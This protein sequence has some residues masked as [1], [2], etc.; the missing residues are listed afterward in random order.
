LHLWLGEY[1]LAA[2][3]EPGLAIWHL[4]QAQHRSGRPDAV[5]G[6]AA[7]DTAT[8]LHYEGAYA[9]A[10]SAF[11][12]LLNA[13]TALRGYDRRVAA[14][15]YRHAIACAGYH[16]QRAKLGVPEPERLD[17]LC[18]V[19]GLAVCLRSLGLPYDRKAALA[20]CRV[21]GEGSSLEDL[22]DAARTLNLTSYCLS[23]DD[24]GLRLLP[25][26]LIAYVEHDHFITVMSADRTGVAYL[27]SDCGP[28]PG[29]RVN[30]TW[31]QW[32]ALAP[33]AYFAISKRGS[34]KDR[35]LS[36]VLSASPRA[37]APIQLA[38][39]GPVAGLDLRLRP[40]QATLAT[41]LRGHVTA[42][43]NLLRISCGNQPLAQHCPPFTHCP[44][45]RPCPPGSGNGPPPSGCSGGGG[46]SGWRPGMIVS[47]SP[48][49]KGKTNKGVAQR[50][51]P[52]QLAYR[53]SG[54]VAGDPVNLATGEEEYEPDPDLVVYN[55]HG[56]AITWSR[57]YE[58][59]RGPAAAYNSDDFGVGWSH[60]YNVLVYDSS[61]AMN[62]QV[63]PGT[64]ANVATTGSDLPGSGL[65]WDI[66]QNG[67]TIATSAS[68]GGWSVSLA[69]GGGFNVTAPASAAA[70]MN[71]EARY[72]NGPSGASGFFDVLAA[73]SVPAG[74]TARL[75][76]NGSDAPAA[77]LTWDVLKGGL[78]VATSANP[79]G[80]TVSYGVGPQGPQFTVSC[81]LLSAVASNYEVRDSTGFQ[82][83]KPAALSVIAHRFKAKAGSKSLVL[84]NG[85]QVFFN[86]ASVPS[87]S[88][89]QVTCGV[90]AGAPMAVE[91][92]YSASDPCGTYKIT[93]PNR[94]K[95]ITTTCSNS[96]GTSG[97]YFSLAQ[98]Q[99][100]LGNAINF[101]YGTYGPTHFPAITSI[102]DASNG[103]TLLTVTRATNGTANITGISDAY[104]RSVYYHVGTYPT[105]NVPAGYPQSFQ[106]VDTVSQIV[107]TGTS[108]PPSRYTYGYQNLSDLEGSEQIPFLHTLTAPS[109]T[110]TGNSTATINYDP[111]TDFVS[112]VVDSNGNKRAYAPADSVHTAVTV[113]NAQNAVAYSYAAGFDS[114]LSVTNQTDG[115][116]STNLF[117]ADYADPNDPYQASSFTD[118]AGRTTSATWDAH[119][120]TQSIT[121]PRG[122]KTQFTVDYSVFSLGRI[123][124][125]QTGTKTPISI[126][127]YEPGG[128]VQSVASP[129]PGQSGG[130]S[131]VA[132]SF[133]YD[134][135]GNPLTR[136]LPGNNAASSIT[137]TC[138][139]TSDGTYSQGDA[140]GEPLTVTD[141]LGK[142]L[143][144]LRWDARGN[145]V[146]RT[147]ALGNE[148][149]LTYNLADQLTSVTYPATGQ[150]GAGRAKNVY[151]YLY[152]G[153]PLT[154]I[155]YYDESAALA[156]QV[157]FT[158]GPEGEFL[159][160]GGSAEPLTVTYDAQYRVVSTQDGNSH[161]TTYT[162]NQ[163]GHLSGIG[164]PGGD[165]IA[166]TS[167]DG[168]GNLLQRVNGRGITTNYLYTDVG[169]LLSDIEYPA[170]P[171]LN[172]HLSYD[173]YD[174]RGT[175]SD[176]CGSHSYS[177]D[178]GDRPTG[179]T[180]TYTGLPA[181]SIT[182]SFYADGSR[183]G[184]STPAGNFGYSYDG[185]G[186][187][188]GL[189]NPYSES[190][191]WT[192]L[193]NNWLKTQ[194]LGNGVTST[195]TY[196]A[197]ARLL[198]IST[199]NS[200]ST[201]LSDFGSMVYDA[202]GN[203][204]SLLASIP[205]IGAYG[206]STSYGYDT[207]NELT[208]EQS[209]RNGSYSNVFGYDGAGNATTFKGATNAFNADNQNTANTWDGDGNPTV[210]QGTS[211]AFDAEDRLTSV[212]A[213]LTAGYNGDDLRA[214]KQTSAGRTYFLYDG[215]TPIIEM[216][217][218]GNVTAV[219]TIGANGL[220]ARRSGGTSVSYAFDAQ[221]SVAQRLD[222]GGNILTNEMFDAYGVGVSDHPASDPFGYLAQEGY[223][224][225]R[226]SGLQLLTRRYYDPGAGRFLNRDPLG[227][228]GGINLY[229]YA[230]DSPVVMS[231]PS[232]LAP[233]SGMD[234]EELAQVIAELVQEIRAR[235]EER[236]VD[237][238]DYY[239]GSVGPKGQT[240]DGEAHQLEGKQQRLRN[241][242][243]RFE[244]LDCRGKGFGVPSNA[245]QWA[246]API[247]VEP[248]PKAAPTKIE[249]W[250]PAFTPVPDP[251]P[252]IPP[253][254][255]N[256]NWGSCFDM[257]FEFAL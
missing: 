39:N 66:V 200:A 202:V 96:A 5:F 70:T 83:N 227:Y 98:I 27:C 158:Y 235:I 46:G 51:K 136:T 38:S 4:R 192:Y 21:T 236:R 108:N 240:W 73:G 129:V 113:S 170:T 197:R 49:E 9:K 244:D 37:E 36:K 162:Y 47:A 107:P 239:H 166:F 177:F 12:R 112:S 125:V 183:S 248:R 87:S 257:D 44:T 179:E 93:F 84:S 56:P 111:A 18:G 189:S 187:P 210:Y 30:L 35:L 95:W 215:E 212:G 110:G 150:T 89:P 209:A 117:T 76:S 169:G 11:R 216:D 61:A 119:G 104:G 24:E 31:Q 163:A 151:A 222:S 78:S 6:L 203:R 207:K 137:T 25:K 82:G 243:K 148:V 134:S 128:L 103:S 1:E 133:T 214:W 221:G 143:W 71:Y 140:I 139:Y 154:S 132:T 237:K 105:T 211:L 242:L 13:K 160:R 26:P 198:E 64:T 126:S 120:T 124:A 58:S 75:S 172:V 153:G 186:R 116:N 68:T 250:Q 53:S 63:A 79:N 219:N 224:T 217:G 3:Q 90:Q 245:W 204:T 65:Q 34:E 45:D 50:D 62:S 142:V 118:G 77:G 253:V 159:S 91:W 145:L 226:E 246:T 254:T 201:L 57:Q 231:D 156:R 223:Y 157:T 88:Q 60:P 225:D 188:T 230:V 152:T 54:A 168:A 180:T 173:A 149:D 59:L 196:N 178:D 176:S 195:Y 72:R 85:A 109:P 42:I 19:A 123:T 10:A 114:N 69:T 97:L 127:Y 249:P 92:D 106:E 147:D 22:R 191:G 184:M 80:W 228:A 199:K 238:G 40:Q 241:A 193:D 32:H 7:F 256:F 255:F 102:T 190:F 208:L 41:L 182:Y 181:R 206:G 220:L 155:S 2:R 205:A 234:C 99:D 81:P 8:A 194:Q 86:A 23:A 141:N 67:S 247:P 74:G 16:E 101:I 131:T 48:A 55:P 165:S 130:A 164:Y 251:C 135:L 43:V 122:T 175:M 121:S 17:P 161:V 174:R 213:V 233:I 33:G 100:R 138:N 15:W 14:L 171:S 167:Y 20:S 252:Q 29:G 146:S 232:G 218:S 185:K 94:S 28:W 144:H 229:G 115:T 52:V